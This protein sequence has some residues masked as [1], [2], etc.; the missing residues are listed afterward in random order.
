M[1]P[2]GVHKFDGR[3]LMGA[4]LLSLSCVSCREERRPPE[5]RECLWEILLR[6]DSLKE[7][8]SKES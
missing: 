1:A 8:H 7:S 4:T 6:R 3:S 2:K 5:E